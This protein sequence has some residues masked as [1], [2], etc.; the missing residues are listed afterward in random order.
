MAE[1]GA[2]PILILGDLNGVVALQEILE[3]AQ[4]E[5]GRSFRAASRIDEGLLTELTQTSPSCCVVVHR[6]NSDLAIG[7]LRTA[8]AVLP[9]APVLLLTTRHTDALEAD[10][11]EVGADD[12][13]SIS[14]LT[15]S[16][17]MRIVGRSLKRAARRRRLLEANPIPMLHTTV[18]GAPHWANDALFKLFRCA[19]LDDVRSLGVELLIA[20]FARAL[21][22]ENAPSHFASQQVFTNLGGDQCDLMMMVSCLNP[23]VPE[24]GVQISFTDI[25][26]LETKRRRLDLAERRAREVYDSSPVMMYT[27]SVDSMILEANNYWLKQMSYDR[28]EVIGVQSNRFHGSN[29][30]FNESSSL[31]Q[32]LLDGKDSGSTEIQQV[33]RDGRIIDGLA[34]ATAVRS[35]V[36]ELVAFRLSVLDLTNFKRAQAERDEMERELRLSQKLESVGQMAAGIAHEINTPAQFVS[37]N[38]AFLGTA[39][40]DLAPVL[41]RLAGMEDVNIQ[42]LLEEADSAFLR[43]EI[44]LSIL[45]AQDGIRRIRKIVLALKEFAHPGGEDK[46]AADLNHVIENTATLARGEWKYVA[47]LSLDL[48]PVMPTVVCDASAI[49]QVVLNMI[50]NAAHAIGDRLTTSERGAAVITVRTLVEGKYFSISIADTGC[51]M[52]E[53]TKSRIFDPFFTTKEVG[54]GSGQGL[55]IARAIVIDQHGGTITVD[56]E[57]GTGTTFTI[58]LPIAE[59][60]DEERR[61]AEDGPG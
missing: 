20:T 13:V 14:G 57:L 53:Q 5:S 4:R 3:R 60:A 31:W 17:F 2:G 22:Q 27:L 7:Q 50:V 47:E 36:G 42:R 43:E 26:E 37:D 30:P 16:A 48:C 15:A 19:N 39:F 40:T 52:S 56:S 25:T 38:L 29:L 44:P 34:Y 8:V 46:M 41:E 9:E 49:A 11:L 18:Q 12:C 35:S 33:T 24:Q 45:Q 51:G 54:R 58:R 59:P 1:V 61:G 28:E 32:D 10:A 55:A 21:N 23:L 6:G